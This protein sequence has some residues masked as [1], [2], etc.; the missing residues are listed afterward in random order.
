MKFIIVMFVVLLE[1]SAGILKS[2]LISVDHKSML[3]SI[4]VEHIDVG[5]S[6]F[7]YHQIT[8]NHSTILNN[9]LVVAYDDKKK[10]ATIQLTPYTGL[11]N[12][13]LPTGK[14][15][16]SV[17]DVA[18]F[19]FGYNRGLLIAPSEE[20]YHQITKNVD[21]QWVHPD[22]FATVLSF[23]GHP[24]P[25]KADFLAMSTLSSVG[26]VFIYLDQK[27]YMVDSK[28]FHILGIN[29]APLV[30]DSVK[31]P[32]YSRIESIP[33]HWWQFWGEANDELEAYAP[34]YYELLVQN[35]PYDT[36]L[37]E[38]IQHGD[39]KLHYLLKQFKIGQ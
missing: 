23:R 26:L 39:A 21:I 37:Y 25:M 12:N 27:V 9:A 4:Q 13:S 36:R 3:A 8:K 2:P 10:I 7:V 28:S 15:V 16:A 17:G 6:G 11:Q 35:N 18:M 38:I 33:S 19:A 14:W 30:E 1:L 32:F 29:E 24:T 31:L 5:M 20:I 22:L 34:H